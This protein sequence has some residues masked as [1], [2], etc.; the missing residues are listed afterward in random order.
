M[1]IIIIINLIF[2]SPMSS[3]LSRTLSR[4]MHCRCQSRGSHGKTLSFRS[5]VLVALRHDAQSARCIASGQ[6]RLSA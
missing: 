6:S 3:I 5:L 4:S 2:L 1:H